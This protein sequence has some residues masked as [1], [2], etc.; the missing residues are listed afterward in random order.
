[1]DKIDDKPEME[2]QKKEWDAE[3]NERM[4]AHK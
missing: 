1:M 4:W 2:G 3:P